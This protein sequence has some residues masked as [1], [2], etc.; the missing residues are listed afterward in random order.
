MDE[1]A[2]KKRDFSAYSFV[3]RNSPK[4]TCRRQIVFSAL[5]HYR[6]M[7]Q[8][9][10]AELSLGVNQHG[11]SD[12]DFLALYAEVDCRGFS[13]I[14]QFVSARR[15]LK[16]FAI[17]ASALA[18]NTAD[19]ALLLGGFEKAEQ[20]L[21]LHLTRA[22][23]SGHFTARVRIAT[24]GPRSD[25][26]NRVETEFIVPPEAFSHFIDALGRLADGHATLSTLTGDVDAIK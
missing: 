21:R 7:N 3:E 6:P 5:P 26:W 8:P 19:S 2:A 17:E 10:L 18:T 4:S 12:S 1:T 15:D 16:L 11:T 13:G 9:P 25:Q 14:T 20:P 22:G 24:S 23:R